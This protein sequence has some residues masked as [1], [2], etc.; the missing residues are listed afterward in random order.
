MK[1][2]SRVHIERRILNSLDARLNGKACVSARANVS[3]LSWR[4]T[5]KEVRRRSHIFLTVRQAKRQQWYE[6]VPQTFHPFHSF[7]CERHEC[8]CLWRPPFL[9][10]DAFS[11]Q[12]IHFEYKAVAPD[13]LDYQQQ[14][15][16]GA[17]QDSSH[18]LQQHV[19][20]ARPHGRGHGRSW[21]TARHT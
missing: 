8:Y 14:S 11:R 18:A 20:L 6:L 5:E 10:E 7:G 1:M 19:S 4:L 12:N 16:L 3:R 15:Q 17:I 2:T 9:V 13:T 21:R